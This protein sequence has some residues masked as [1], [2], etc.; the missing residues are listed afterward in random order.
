MS[1][2][3]RPLAALPRSS[4]LGT[5]IKDTPAA[6]A[7]TASASFQGISSIRT[8]HPAQVLGGGVCGGQRRALER[9]R[10]PT[11]EGATASPNALASALSARQPVQCAAAIVFSSKERSAATVSG[12]TRSLPP[13]RWKPPITPCSRRPAKHSRDLKIIY[14]K[15]GVR[16]R[17][18]MVYRY[19]QAFKRNGAEP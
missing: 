11:E 3:D 1:G 19:A 4:L 13:E 18:A 12:M 2:A 6:C 14:C 15:L 8:P 7:Q 17:G 9:Y 10:L 5:R 16:S